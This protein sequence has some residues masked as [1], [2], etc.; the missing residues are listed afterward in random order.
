K[1]TEA[2]KLKPSEQYPKTKLAELDA[3]IKEQEDQENKKKLYEAAIA[4]GD[5]LF[6]S[7]SWEESKAKYQEA[8]KY[9]SAAT[10]PAARVKMIDEKLAEL[11]AAKEKEEQIAK[12]L[13]EG[14]TALAGKKYAEALEKYKG[15]IALDAANA[16]ATQK[17]PEI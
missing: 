3:K 14:A 15:V 8:L 5:R 10:Y 1:Y 6:D 4:E 7:E 17:I 11:K 16:T 2:S 9:E 12:L 13:Q